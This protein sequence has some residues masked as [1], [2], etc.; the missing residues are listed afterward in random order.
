[1]FSGAAGLVGADEASS[2]TFSVTAVF[3]GV[4]FSGDAWFGGVTFSGDTRFS[5]V[6]FSGDA[7]F[8]GTT[9]SGDA[10][11]ESATFKRRAEFGGARFEQARQF[12]PLLAYRGLVLDDVRFAQPVKI[13]VSS[14][15]VCCRRAR[16][17]GGVQF[18]LRWARVVLDDTDL[19][20][21][22][23]LAG[24]HWLFG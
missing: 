5:G 6:T 13:E 9:F 10:R 3:S 15:G 4:T 14:T 7:W 11:F 2:A 24:R 8:G 22:C 18:R 23:I 19:A 12:G 1:V 21:P 17:P 16:F 20:A